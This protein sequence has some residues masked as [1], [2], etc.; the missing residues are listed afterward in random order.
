[1]DK[2]SALRIHYQKLDAVE[3]AM[4]RVGLIEATTEELMWQALWQ[5]MNKLEPLFMARPISISMP[6]KN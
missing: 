6:S 3:R 4:K 2:E 1:M 5:A